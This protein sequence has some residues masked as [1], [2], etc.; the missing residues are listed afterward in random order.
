MQDDGLKQRLQGLAEGHA[1][2]VFG[3]A[4]GLLLEQAFPGLLS[5]LPGRFTRAA[6]AGIRLQDAVLEDIVDRPTPLYLHNY[7]QV[8][9]QL[10]RLALVLADCLQQEGYAALAVPASQLVGKDPLRGHVSHKLLGWA[11]GIGFIG[12]STLLVN[13]RYG[14]RVRYVS[15]LT[16]APLPA[17]RPCEGDCGSCRECVPA[18]PAGA[19]GLSHK[20]F[21]LDACTRRLSE[22]ARL[23]FIGQH[24]CGICVRAC[25]GERS[26]GAAT[27][28]G[29]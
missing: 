24:I 18:C 9:Y 25:R 6:V 27:G 12:R 3:V 20:A 15:V 10:D 29:A 11:A 22:F 1:A 13:P 21:D 28:E 8:N 14:A 16:T 2:C 23:P 17:D 4:D 7:R 26:A 19:I 5:R